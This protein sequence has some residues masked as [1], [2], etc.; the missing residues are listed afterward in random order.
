MRPRHHGHFRHAYQAAR[1]TPQQSLGLGSYRLGAP[2]GRREA[3]TLLLRGTR[4]AS[5]E[6]FIR[7]WVGVWM[8]NGM[9]LPQDA[10]AEPIETAIGEEEFEPP[11]K[12]AA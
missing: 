12:T 2:H 5:F 10:F 6:R 7:T 1:D 3:F 11:R 9:G 4:R 8:P